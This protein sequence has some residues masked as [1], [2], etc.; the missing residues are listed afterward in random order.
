MKELSIEEKAKRYD[1]AIKR[2]KNYHSPETVCNVRIAMENLFPELVDL[3]DERIRKEIIKYFKKY[4]ALSLG[5][6]NVQDILAW[7]EK[8]GEQKPNFCHHEV[9]LSEC[10]EEYRKAYYDG[11]NNCN[12]Q[13]AQLEAEQKPDSL[14]T[15]ARLLL[16]E[17]SKSPY[18]NKPITDAQ[19]IIK[20]L[21]NFL[22][23]STSYN[24]NALNE[25]KPTDKVKLKFKV[26]DWIVFNGLTL[27]IKEIVKGYYGTISKGGIT[28]SYD[29]DIDNTARLWTIQDAKDGDVLATL[30][31]ILI[32]KGFLK[33]DGGISYCHYDFGAG[34]PQFVWFEDKNWYFGKEAIVHPATKKQREQLEKAMA[35]AVYTFD[36]EKKELKKIEQKTVEWSDEDEKMLEELLNYCDTSIKYNGI[37]SLQAIKWKKRKEW[38]KSIKDKVH[39]KPMNEWSEGDETILKILNELVDTTPSKDFFDDTKEKCIIWLKSLKD[40]V[41]PQPKQEWSEEDED[42]CYKAIAVINRLCAEGK[43]YVWSI[44]TLKKLFDWLKS[45]RPQSHWKPSDEQIEVLDEITNNHNLP[46]TQTQYNK[47]INL[48]DDLK[49]LR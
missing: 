44:K 21:L 12:Q 38:L 13:H 18:N 17:L 3:E 23:D 22:K 33:N 49:K 48:Q 16:D 27:Y 6:Y 15:T 20:E 40:R 19:T 26:G 4:Q 34:N 31:Y 28:N 9:D 14:E 10:S 45:L 5:D 32:F 39:P 36:F 30:D 37:K 41:L 35:D 8:Q 42:M 29:W 24:P 2:A 11:W 1:E 43:D 25:Q 46:V 47:L 7:L